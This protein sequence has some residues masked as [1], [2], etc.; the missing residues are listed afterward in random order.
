VAVNLSIKAHAPGDSAET[1]TIIGAS[2]RAAAQSAR[3]AFFSPVAAD[4]F[5]D[6]DL[7]EVAKTAQ[8]VDYPQGF[9]EVLAGSQSG[10]WLY[11]GALENYPDLIERWQTIRPL[12]GN[13]AAV[14]RRV[15]DPLQVADCLC[16]RGLMCP[17]VSLESDRLPRN[18][19]WLRKPL[20]SAAG[21]HIEPWSDH[22][23]AV[24]TDAFYFQEKVEG[25]PLSAAFLAANGSAFLIGVT[26][27]LLLEGSLRYA[28]SLG[29]LP[30]CDD[31]RSKWVSLGELFAKEFQLVG[32]FGVDAICNENGIWPVEIN[33]RYTASMEILEAASAS[34][35]IGMHVTACR[36]GRLPTAL[37]TDRRIYGKQ[38]CFARRRLHIE[39]NLRSRFREIADVP[40]TNTNFA[41][42]E[43]VVTF[44]RSGLAVDDVRNS[45]QAA[46]DGF[47]LLEQ[48][49]S[50][51]T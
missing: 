46:V 27:Q 2:T 4:L 51:T 36:E 14:L 5:A 31:E 22:S 18:G 28:G 38:I 44:L 35:L 21:M 8:I 49:Q 26:R 12:L 20:Q 45:L 48:E 41:H 6:V 42:G 25:E 24:D 23:S 29:P 19:Q 37:A 9:E 32:L 43:P 7:Q 11:T 50:A 3:R 33:P 34:S 15:R 16:Q 17:K 30:L 10:D 39:V 1:L 47:R 40:Q 13:S